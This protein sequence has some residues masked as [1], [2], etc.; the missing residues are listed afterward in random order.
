MLNSPSLFASPAGC[1]MLKCHIY[2]HLI[3]VVTKHLCS[4]QT[5]E[6]STEES[7]LLAPVAIL[8]CIVFYTPV[9]D[10]KP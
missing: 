7:S 1:K 5:G 3:W 4:L 6:K 10:F 9:N 2:W 8:S